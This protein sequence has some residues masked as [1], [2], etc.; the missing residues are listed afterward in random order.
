MPNT[1]FDRFK[2]LFA[3]LKALIKNPTRIGALAPSSDRLAREMASHLPESI[4]GI[5][6]ELG[7]GTGV[8][9]RALLQNGVNPENLIV[10]ERSPIMAERIRAQFSRVSVIEGDAE[11]L[12]LLLTQLEKNRCKV[13]TVISSL[14]LL[15]LPSAKVEAI[16]EQIASVLSEKGHYV[17]FSYGFGKKNKLFR[18]YFRLI[19]EK[20]IWLNFPPAQVNVW[21]KN[22]FLPPPE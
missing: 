22:N 1:F 20:R 7:A 6:V 18:H 21:M 15:I 2:N 10:I 13:E 11:D 16:L 12:T 14:P 3:F 9:T 4:H 8:I 5:V 19:Q 17:Q